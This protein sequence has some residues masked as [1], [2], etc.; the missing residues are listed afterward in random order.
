MDWLP[1]SD[2]RCLSWAA[3]FVYVCVCVRRCLH[4]IVRGPSSIVLFPLL[5]AVAGIL[6]TGAPSQLRDLRRWGNFQRR[7]NMVP[8]VI[9]CCDFPVQRRW[10]YLYFLGV[11]SMC[12]IQIWMC[13]WIGYLIPIV[14]ACHGLLDLCMCVCVRY[15]VGTPCL[16]ESFCWGCGCYG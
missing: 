12:V 7:G 15:R 1:D 6:R 4:S 13:V 9:A 10:T 5:G 11:M 8:M 3:G 2:R 14:V 16:R